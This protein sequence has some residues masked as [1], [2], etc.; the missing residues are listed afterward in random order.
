MKPS[1]VRREISANKN[2][3]VP[4]EQY[5][6]V[7]ADRTSR[8]VARVWS[9]YE[10]ELRRAD[11]LDFDDLLLRTVE[12]LRAH[13]DIRAGYQR[14]VAAHP[15]RRVPGH[16]PDAGAA[17]AGAGRTRDLMA[18]GDDKQVIYGFRLADVRL[19]LDFEKEY[20]DARVLTLE[21]NYRN[22][23]QILKAANRLIAHNLVQRPWRYGRP[24]APRMAPRSRCTS[25]A[26]TRRRRS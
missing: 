19:I 11:A 8:I 5:A 24:R 10:R 3:A 9:E 20:R 16:K 21:E 13:P 26:P 4:V 25:R 12:L 7:A 23:P 15:R 17:A 14:E 1:V 22:S 2:H 6:A 18:T